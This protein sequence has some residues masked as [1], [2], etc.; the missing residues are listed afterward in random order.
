MAIHA[1]DLINLANTPVFVT[2]VS[3]GK[4]LGFKETAAQLVSTNFTLCI[5]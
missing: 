5:F 1:H 4:N 2:R 3:P